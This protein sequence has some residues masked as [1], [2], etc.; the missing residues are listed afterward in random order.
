[1]SA[2]LHLK[3]P[4]SEFTGTIGD[5]QH[6]F[7]A[8]EADALSYRE[9]W[10]RAKAEMVALRTEYAA[11]EQRH[12]ALVALCTRAVAQWQAIEVSDDLPTGD[13]EKPACWTP[14]EDETWDDAPEWKRRDVEVEV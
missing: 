13:S 8:L 10:E 12:K 11:L 14:L 6:H 9:Q 1:M 7:A 4:S 3:T 5:L 2:I